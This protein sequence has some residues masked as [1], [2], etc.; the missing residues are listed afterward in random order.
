[1]AR[2][3]PAHK[4]E[5]LLKLL[6]DPRMSPGWEGDRDPLAVPATRM[7]RRDKPHVFVL[8]FFGDVRASQA[9]NLREEVTAVLR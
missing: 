6:A 7:D 2:A 3:L 1:M 4:R 5:R 9:S 8:Q